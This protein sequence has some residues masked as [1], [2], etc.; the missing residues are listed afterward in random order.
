MAQ[1]DD[2]KQYKGH[3]FVFWNTRS[4]VPRLEEVQ[5]II[6]KAQPEIIGLTETWLNPNIDNPQVEFD[7]YI[8]IRSDRTSASLKKGGGGLV[9]YYRD[10]LEIVSLPEHTRC[11]PD[12][13][14][15]WVGLKLINTKLIVIG[16][17][18]RPPSGKV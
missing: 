3:T 14:C 2:L 16:L 8:M 15:M 7:K 13:E 9:V 5:R 11:T 6:D 10:N 1:L 17:V 4:L 12:I 18:Y